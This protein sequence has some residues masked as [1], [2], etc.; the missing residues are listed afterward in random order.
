MRTSAAHDFDHTLSLTVTQK[1]SCPPDGCRSTKAPKV[2][3][4][5]R[6]EVYLI[7][8]PR[9]KD[10]KMSCKHGQRLIACCRWCL[11]VLESVCISPLPVYYSTARLTS[12]ADSWRQSKAVDCGTEI[13]VAAPR[14][15][16]S[17]KLGQFSLAL[18]DTE[19]DS[20]CFESTDLHG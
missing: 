19:T 15:S 8:T 5:T 3:I 4:C 16:H 7:M 17:Q 11:Q 10:F 2:T 12:T 6:K 9:K 13:I 18:L 14:L 20:L 1:L